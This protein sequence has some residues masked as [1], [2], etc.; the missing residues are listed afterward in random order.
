MNRSIF[1]WACVLFLFFFEQN[2]FAQKIKQF[3]YQLSGKTDNDS[4]AFTG[5]DRYYSNGLFISL[6][7][8]INSENKSWSPNT[9]KKIYG[10]ELGHEI[11]MSN[12]SQRGYYQEDLID[13]PYA[14]YIYINGLWAIH[15]INE[16][17]LQFSGAVGIIGPSTKV[18]QLQSWTHNAFGYY[19]PMGWEHQIEDLWGINLSINYRRMLLNNKAGK[20]FFD[21]S[22]IGKGD[23][24]TFFS[25]ASASGIIRLGKLE[26]AFN[27]CVFNAKPTN[28]KNASINERDHEWAFYLQPSFN[29]VA[30]NATIQGGMFSTQ[31]SSEEIVKPIQPWYFGQQVGFMYSQNRWGVDLSYNFKSKET[32]HA[33]K[34]NQY[35]SFKLLYFFN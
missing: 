8:A 14:G 27:S 2:I 24:G 32:K 21:A 16:S 29:Y 6:R 9:A 33:V 23:L 3:H 26:K 12:V 10:I 4:Y 28:S 11:Y 13:R 17:S 34:T 15:Y 5:G 7:K 31:F 25:G 1:F 19:H 22:I 18:D 35:G 30:Y 20:R